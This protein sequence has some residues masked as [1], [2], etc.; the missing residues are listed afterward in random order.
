MESLNK[1]LTRLDD[2]NRKYNSAIKAAKKFKAIFNLNIK[3][4]EREDFINNGMSEY[5]ALFKLE[6]K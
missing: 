6:K 3:R 5:E 4:K 2:I 1:Y